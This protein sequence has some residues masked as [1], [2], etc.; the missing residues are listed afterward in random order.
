MV[1]L[2]IAGADRSDQK[3]HPFAELRDQPQLYGKVVG[4]FE[5]A[6]KHSFRE[7][8]DRMG[9]EFVRKIQTLFEVRRRFKILSKWYQILVNESRFSPQ[10]AIDEIPRA[11]RAELDGTPYEPPQSTHLWTP[12]AGG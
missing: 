1:D 12:A 9:E 6:L 7:D 5:K 2:L 8:R 3:G 4:G 11:L 10:H